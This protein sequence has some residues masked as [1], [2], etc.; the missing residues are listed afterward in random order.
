MVAAK[1]AERE[2]SKSGMRV[3]DVALVEHLRCIDVANNHRKQWSVM[4]VN[5]DGNWK[6]KRM[7]G[8]IGYKLSEK[9]WSFNSKKSALEE[10]KRL[11]ESK[12]RKGYEVA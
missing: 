8:R 1:T 4:V 11:V 5:E 6:Q 9:E 7:W 10:A 2:E 12:I 3:V